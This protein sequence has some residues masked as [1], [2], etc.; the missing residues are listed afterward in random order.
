MRLV[1]LGLIAFVLYLGIKEKKQNEENIANIKI[2]V[3]VNGTRGKSTATRLITAVLD[4]AGYNTLGKTTGTAA[5][6]LYKGTETKIKRKKEGSNI[7]E[8]IAVI[9]QAKQKEANALVCECMAV[10]PDY[11]KVYSH[12]IIKANVCVIVNVLEDHLDVM[13]PTTD[14]MAL[15]FGET[16]PY[17]GTLIITHSKYTKYFKDI[18]KKRNTKVYVARNQDIPKG[19][20]EKFSYV[21]FPDNVALALAVARGLKID[22]KVALEGMLKANP[23]PGALNIKEIHDESKDINFNFV[24]AFAANEPAS[25]LAIIDKV[26]DLKYDT[27]DLV[28]LFNGRPD[29]IDRTDQFVRDFF[30]KLPNCVLV[31]MGQAIGNIKK[32]FDEGKYPNVKEYLHLE[33][34]NP[35]TI[36]DKMLPYL[37]NKILLGVGNIHGDGEELINDIYKLNDEEVKQ[38]FE[39]A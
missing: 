3:N 35:E 1:I 39:I 17:N 38:K 11:Q 12:N 14:Q 2:R 15:A 36:V 31:G 20:L 30:P 32:G 13:G 33:N 28:V 8:Q 23:D 21:L 22:K 9:R 7:K 6:L 24:N 18:A 4:E 34:G 37:K 25:S 27:E 26:K 29:R 19:Y 5:R 10:R 16:I